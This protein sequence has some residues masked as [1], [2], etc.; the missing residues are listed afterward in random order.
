MNNPKI[1]SEASAKNAIN[2]AL[3]E[4]DLHQLAWIL[5][6]LV[7]IDNPVVVV[8]NVND[9]KTAAQIGADDSIPCSD[10]FVNG[11]NVG[12]LNANGT[13]DTDEDEEGGDDEED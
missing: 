8:H 5:S 4:C 9:D 12:T 2:D 11:E 3:E 6:E 13:V 7:E 1:Y 10:C